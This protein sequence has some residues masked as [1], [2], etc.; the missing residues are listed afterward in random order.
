MTR[1]QML[2][3]FG[4]PLAAVVIAVLTWM[5]KTAANSWVSG[6][7]TEAVTAQAA[8]DSPD[9]KTLQGEV[10]GLKVDVVVLT[11][12]LKPAQRRELH[13]LQG[14]AQEVQ[15]EHPHT[16]GVNT[17]TGKVMAHRAMDMP[18]AKKAEKKVGPQ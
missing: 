7:V 1:G 8:K 12:L 17:F 3:W 18:A 14:V 16:F 5:G 2:K 4:P 11:Q 9:I 13:E 15:A 6:I 10:R